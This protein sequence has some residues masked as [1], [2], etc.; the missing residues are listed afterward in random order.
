MSSSIRTIKWIE[1]LAEQEL[2]IRSGA[3]VAI[4]ITATK[5][6]VLL[7]ET[8]SFLREFYSHCDYLI[9]LFNSRVSEVGL[10]IKLRRNGEKLDGF[11]ISRNSMRLTVQQAQAGVIGVQCEKLLTTEVMSPTKASTMFSSTIE[12]DF[13]S[14]HDVIW[15]CLGNPV[16]AEQLARHYLTEFIQASR[17]ISSN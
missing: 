11:S 7:A 4:D 14:F 15:Q 9:G 16:T 12:A 6:E 3:R 1:N 17:L 5:D 10:D 2:L 13:G 8:V